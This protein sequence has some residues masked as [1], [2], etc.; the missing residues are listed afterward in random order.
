MSVLIEYKKILT[1]L[2]MPD[3]I[4]E[5]IENLSLEKLYRQGYRVLFLDVDNTLM[6]HEHRQV[7]L[8]RAHWIETMKGIGF[9]IYLLS[10][11]SSERRIRKV[12]HQ[13]KVEGVYFACK[14]FSYSLKDLADRHQIDLKK[15]IIIG[16]QLLKD[17]VL[18]NW[19]EMYTILV[20]P[21]DIRRSF[22]KTMQRDIELWI[23]D[24][25]SPQISL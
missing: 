3:L 7:S 13:L 2:F 8:Q 16:D 23:L 15:S 12:C 11:N 10:N 9:E 1:D 4:E 25:L 18:G 17:V 22:F 20:N 21:L 6:T 19:F 24:K 5:F 14:P